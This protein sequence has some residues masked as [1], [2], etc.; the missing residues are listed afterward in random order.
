MTTLAVRK[1]AS[2]F[3]KQ[4]SS[5]KE[6]NLFIEDSSSVPG[7][8]D[9]RVTWGRRGNARDSQYK[10]QGVSMLQAEATFES[11]KRSKESKGYKED[12]SLARGSANIPVPA[13][14]II[15]NATTAALKPSAPEREYTELKPQLLNPIGVDEME[16]Y[17]LSP[18]YLAQEKLDGK[19]IMVEVN[20]GKVTASNRRSWK[21]GIP[22]DV[23]EELSKF[24]DCILDGELVNGVYCVFDCLAHNGNDIRDES[25]SRRFDILLES[26]IGDR[27]LY[28]VD[29]VPTAYSEADKR[30]LV[31]SLQHK[32]GVV[33]KE[34]SA[35]HSV[36]R[37]N[38]GGSQLKCKFWSSATCV[39][40]KI[41]TT[42]NKDDVADAL[43]NIADG[44]GMVQVGPAFNIIEKA[45][46]T[47]KR[48]VA[49]SVDSPD[50][51]VPV[52][53]VTVPP[54]YELPQVGDCVEIKYLYH[55]PGGALYQPQYLGVRDDVDVDVLASLKPKSED[56][57][58]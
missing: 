21:V 8:Y 22:P 17:I 14:S 38:K 53:N 34:L 5:D 3:F 25:Y 31:E 50:G 4:G 56:T 41:N 10:A 37:P 1:Q 55:Y 33:F 20:F 36:G 15:G 57:D 29:I 58:E 30:A 32:E 24:D 49:V 43:A 46:K 6:Y 42:A 54:N 35:P 26:V 48:S 28:Q 11:Q 2:L 47:A 51:F 9:V 44:N 7:S 13:S 27:M 39:V 40:T 19:R 18:D 16:Q 12:L 23:E 45:N 52:G